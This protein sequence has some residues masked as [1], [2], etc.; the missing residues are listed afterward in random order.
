MGDIESAREHIRNAMQLAVGMT[1]V[2]D[3]AE[4]EQVQADV[5]ERLRKALEELGNGN[6]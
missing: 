5:L 3:W 1:R 2:R 4:L 6:A